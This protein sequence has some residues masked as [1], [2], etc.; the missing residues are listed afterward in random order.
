MIYCSVGFLVSPQTCTHM[1][2]LSKGTGVFSTGPGKS[3]LTKVPIF[4]YEFNCC[5]V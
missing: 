2:K 5:F 1:E 3:V 4:L